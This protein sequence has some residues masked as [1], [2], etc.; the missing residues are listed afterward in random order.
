MSIKCWRNWGQINSD[1]VFKMYL[2]NPILGKLWSLRISPK[3]FMVFPELLGST[4]PKLIWYRRE[5]S[6]A[7]KNAWLRAW[8]ICHKS[9][10]WFTTPCWRH[11]K[12]LSELGAWKIEFTQ[13]RSCL[14]FLNGPT[15]VIPELGRNSCLRHPKHV[16]NPRNHEG[17]CLPSVIVN[18]FFGLRWMKDSQGAF[19]PSIHIHIYIYVFTYIYIYTII[20]IYIYVYVYITL[21]CPLKNAVVI[22][23]NMKS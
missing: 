8:P 7:P 10:G 18:S 20:F 19:Q 2:I 23:A 21:R 4:P 3:N 22:T 1:L 9:V 11:R 17:F 14:F 6:P 16:S 15:S 13:L 5:M 12:F